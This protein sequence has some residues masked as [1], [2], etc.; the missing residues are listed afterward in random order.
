IPPSRPKPAPASFFYTNLFSVG[1]NLSSYDRYTYYRL[2]SQMGVESAPEPVDERDPNFK[3]NLNYVNVGGLR[4]TNFVSWT[5]LQFFTNAADRL[6]RSQL[7][8]AVTNIPVY[9]GSNFVYSPAVHRL[10]QLSA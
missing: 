10:L 8:I 5:P 2:L 6:L 9:Q 3:L 1:T 4:A 7:G